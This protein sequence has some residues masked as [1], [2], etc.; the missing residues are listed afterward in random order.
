MDVANPPVSPGRLT[1]THP[2]PTLCAVRFQGGFS[3]RIATVLL[4]SALLAVLAIAGC[5]S[6]SGPEPADSTVE[7]LDP[8]TPL[9]V[10][11]NLKRA[12]GDMNVE[13][14]MECLAPEFVFHLDD[15]DVAG[16][17]IPEYWLAGTERAIHTNMFAESPP[18]SSLKVKSIQLTLTLLSIT[19]D[20]MEPGGPDYDTATVSED[21]DLRVNLANGITYLVNAPANYVLRLEQVNTE[22]GVEDSW[23]IIEWFDIGSAS[24]GGRTESSSWGLVKAM[25]R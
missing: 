10:M 16:G 15:G 4:G 20:D 22:T 7:Y 11:T 18:D 8:T 9:N 14:Y 13:R 17:D 2:R 23:T 19:Y 21:V 25:Y 24:V 6:T 5:S 3:M 12:Y 1:I